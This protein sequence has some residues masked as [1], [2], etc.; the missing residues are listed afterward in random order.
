MQGPIV[1]TL[2]LTSSYGPTNLASSC[3]S[4]SELRSQVLRKVRTDQIASFCQRESV[5]VEHR[6]PTAA[7]FECALISSSLVVASSYP[8]ELPSEAIWKQASYNLFIGN[9]PMNKL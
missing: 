8:P 6:V 3:H 2:P 5:Q 4:N 9:L 7:R 1:G